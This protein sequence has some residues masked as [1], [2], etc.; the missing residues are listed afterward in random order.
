MCFILED[1]GRVH[2]AIPVKEVS[3]PQRLLSGFTRTLVESEIVQHPIM[4]IAHQL[5]VSFHQ[6][7]YGNQSIARSR[8]SVIQSDNIDVV[9][10]IVPLYSNP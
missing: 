8:A 7:I 1:G 4:D 5:T 6:F 10:S 2:V 9:Q 3:E